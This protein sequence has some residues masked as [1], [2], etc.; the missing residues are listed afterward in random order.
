M[1]HLTVALTCAALFAITAQTDD[2]QPLDAIAMK[3][4]LTART[5]AYD[6]GATQHF[7]ADGSTTYTTDHASNGAWRVDGLRYCSQWPP[8]DQWS[9]YSVDRSGDGLDL[10]FTAGDGSASVGRYVDLR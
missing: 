9:C 4:A 8:S 2:W 10:R 7:S 1:R 3:T 5:L 6:G